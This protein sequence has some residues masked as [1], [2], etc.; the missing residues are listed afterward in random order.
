MSHRF[1]MLMLAIS[2]AF[3]TSAAMAEDHHHPHHA[4]AGDVEA[5]HSILAPV[6]HADPGRERSRNA[7]AKGGEMEQAARD[8]RSAD[9]A[10][11]LAA[12]TAFKVQCKDKPSEA[13]AALADVHTAFHR[14]IDRKPVAAR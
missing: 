5:F 6:W 2:A 11:L 1:A 9:A 13:D 14:L 12:I 7:C 10:S 4:F 8:I 3:S